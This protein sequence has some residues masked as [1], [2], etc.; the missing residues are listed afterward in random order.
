MAG[1]LADFI[2]IWCVEVQL[3]AMYWLLPFYCTTHTVLYFIIYDLIL[4]NTFSTQKSSLKHV[5]IGKSLAVQ[6]KTEYI[7]NIHLQCRHMQ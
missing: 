5:L 7:V 2:V 3:F 1:H 4:Y 6:N